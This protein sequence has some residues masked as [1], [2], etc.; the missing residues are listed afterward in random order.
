MLL[1]PLLVLLACFCVAFAVTPAQAQQ[2][3][4]GWDAPLQTNGTPVPDPAFVTSFERGPSAPRNDFTGWVGMKVTVGGAPITVQAL[5]TACFCRRYP[6]PRGP[7]HDHGWH[8]RHV[9][10]GPLRWHTRADH[11]R[12]PGTAGDLAAQ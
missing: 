5:G 4:L 11:L 12:A 1:R 7:D 6:P 9:C 3:Q 10:A 2:V 8:V